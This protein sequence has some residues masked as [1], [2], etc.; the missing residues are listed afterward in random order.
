MTALSPTASVTIAFD[1]GACV[2]H[3]AHCQSAE[4][5]RAI[6]TEGSLYAEHTAHCQNLLRGPTT[7]RQ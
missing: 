6:N 3:T 4:A 7:L 1:L 2:E 5:I